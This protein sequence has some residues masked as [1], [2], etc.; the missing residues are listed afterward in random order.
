MSVYQ[1]AQTPWQSAGSREGVAKV[2]LFAEL[3]N[4]IRHCVWAVSV[5]VHSS[6]PG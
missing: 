6:P 4:G 5:L 1:T 2:L 3:Q